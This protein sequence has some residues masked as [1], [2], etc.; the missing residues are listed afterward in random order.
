MNK[1]LNSDGRLLSL[2]AFRGI[3]MFLLAAE[4]S[5]IYRALGNAFSPTSI[6]GQFLVQFHHHAWNGL[7]FWDL[8]QPFFMFIVGVAMAYSIH[9][10]LS[11]G[12]SWKNLGIHFARRSV[13]LFFLG[14]LLHCGYAQE[15]RWEL[16]NVLT[17]LSFTI[18]VTF[19]VLRMKVNTQILISFG[20]LLLTEILYRFSGVEGFDKPFV[21]GQNFGSWMDMILMGKINGGGWV[22]INALPTA[23]HTVWGMIVGNFLIR[24]KSAQKILKTLIIA[25]TAGLVLG[26][27]M[28]WSGIT[29]IIKRIATTSFVITSGGWCL[30]SL[31]LLYWIV[32][33]KGYN[34][35]VIFFAIVGMNSIFIYMFSEVV[36]ALWFDE[37]MEIFTGGFLGM[38][39]AG[40]TIINLVTAV[41][42]LTVEWY[43]VYWLY[44]RK[45]FIRI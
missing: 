16:W 3:T 20:L 43:L 44:K 26:Y 5:H 10:R 11:M 13:I 17:Q 33:L 41:C 34:R 35:W 12:D 22:A 7:R 39:G 45:I 8:I 25:G 42:V 6:A 31:A 4:A 15:L 36:V 21:Q 32:D 14:V 28:D 19:A 38:I 18:M 29:P 2:D 1:T 23:A 30:L 27:S 37:Y 9:K 24:E 40:E